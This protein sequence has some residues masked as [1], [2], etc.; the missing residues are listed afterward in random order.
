MLGAGGAGRAAAWALREA[1]AE[2]SIWN[3]TSQRAAELAGELGVRHAERT[4]PAEVL[5]NSTSV[6]L[7][8][9]GEEPEL[10][11]ALGLTGLEPPA[12]VVDMVYGARADR[13]GALG[14]VGRARGRSTA[15]RCSC[16]RAPAASRCGPAPTLRS[17]S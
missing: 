13:P 15:S 7:E 11:A 1:G 5:V 10:P 17:T 6:G 9:G 8:P 14:R 12:L 3:R 16:T 4:E 2:V